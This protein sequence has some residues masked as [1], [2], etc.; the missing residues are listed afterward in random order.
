MTA[1]LPHKIGNVSRRTATQLAESA[2]DT[3][4]ELYRQRMAYVGVSMD[5]RGDIWLDRVHDTP[6]R[7]LLMTCTRKSD[8][9]LLADNIRAEVKARA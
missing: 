4:G 1:S 9:D 6:T 5:V 7:E 2:I 8:P 3:I